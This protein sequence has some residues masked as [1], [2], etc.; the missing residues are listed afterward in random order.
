MLP[1]K[2]ISIS[3]SIIWRF[4]IIIDEL[5]KENLR[6]DDLWEKLSTKFEDVNQFIMC[7]D[8]LFILNNLE[9][10]ESYEVLKYVERN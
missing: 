3:E 1:N 8:A 7:L 4:P 10:N 9:Y 5:K 6:V 2:V